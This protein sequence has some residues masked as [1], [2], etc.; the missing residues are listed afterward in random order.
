M[1]YRGEKPPSLLGIFEQIDVLQER[2]PLEGINHSL[3]SGS[4]NPQTSTQ[5]WRI[6]R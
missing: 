1:E 4:I 3:Q 2:L 6:R 5:T